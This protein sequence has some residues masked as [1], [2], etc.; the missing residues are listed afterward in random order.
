[1]AIDVKTAERPWQALSPDE[2]LERRIEAWLAPPGIKFASPEAEKAYKARV[3][4]IADAVQMKKTP[5]RTPVL[6]TQGGFYESYCGYT[7]KDIMYDVNKSI[8]VATRGTQDFDFDVKLTAGGQPGTTYEMV[9]NKAYKW[10]GHGLPDDADGIQYLEDE[11][12]KEDEYDAFLEDPTNFRLRVLLPRIWGVAEPLSKLQSMAQGNVASFAPFALPEVKAALDKLAQAG[13][14]AIAWQQKAGAG[15][16]KLTELGFPSLLGGAN[17][18]VPFAQFG[19]SLRGT[20]GIY[21]DVLQR[22][23]KLLEAMERLV[24]ILIKRCV[25]G[26]RLGDSPIVDLHLHKGA[27]RVM[28]REQFRIFYW[29]PVKKI[30]L[31]VIQEG[32]IPHMRLEGGFNTR[33]E[34]MRRDL[35]KSKTLWFLSWET[36]LAKAKEIAGGAACLTS[37]IPSSLLYTGTP[38]EIDAHCRQEF[39][40]AGKDGGFIFCMPMEGINRNTKAENV[41]AAVEAAK[42]HG[43][44]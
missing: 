44:Y 42:K 30:I 23:Q 26:A 3:R 40:I 29:E 15:N 43:A 11:Y 12:M 39:E 25:A 6:P 41:R 4:R 33:L 27:D 38:E 20:R 21:R 37:N 17:I 36:D 1:M 5:D 22:P 16:R 32:L 35:P 28:S 7:H 10:P 19:D 31:A 24:P 8:D 13:Q 2:K 14:S 34:E 18:G 9:G